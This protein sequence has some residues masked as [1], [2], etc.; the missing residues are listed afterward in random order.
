MIVELDRDVLRANIR[1]I[2]NDFIA[3]SASD[4]DGKGIDA[5]PFEDV[6]FVVENFDIA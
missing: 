3:V 2:D 5:R 6:S 4:T 1:I